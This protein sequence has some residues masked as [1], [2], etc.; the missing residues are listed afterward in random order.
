MHGATFVLKTKGHF[1]MVKEA[2]NY[3]IQWQRTDLKEVLPSSPV[4]FNYISLQ[5]SI[6]KYLNYSQYSWFASKISYVTEVS[7]SMQTNYLKKNQFSIWKITQFKGNRRRFLIAV[8]QVQCFLVR[9][10]T[11][12]SA[13]NTPTMKILCNQHKQHALHKNPRKSLRKSVR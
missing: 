2:T 3:V 1:S 7:I 4:Y 13:K 5:K 9:T 10:G 11:V 8:I 6:L 12:T